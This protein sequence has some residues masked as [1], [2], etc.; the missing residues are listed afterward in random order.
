[1]PEMR[2]S[3]SPSPQPYDGEEGKEEEDGEQA[4]EEEQEADITMVNPENEGATVDDDFDEKQ[5]LK[6][7]PRRRTQTIVDSGDEGT[8]DPFSILKPKQRT[9]GSPQDDNNENAMLPISIPSTNHR[10]SLSSTD[11]RTE[12]EN[13]KENN[14]SLMFDHSENKENKAVVRHGDASGKHPLGART[15]SL[16]GL[17]LGI[18]RRL[19]MS[20]VLHSQGIDA[21]DEDDESEEGRSPLKDLLDDDPFQVTSSKFSTSFAV[22]L[23]Q[24]SPAATLPPDTNLVPFIGKGDS[25]PH[26]PTEPSGI[27]RELLQ[28]GFSDLFESGTE[29][30]KV[31]PF[32]RPAGFGLSESFSDEV[33]TKT[34]HHCETNQRMLTGTSI[35]QT[36]QACSPCA[37]SDAGCRSSACIPNR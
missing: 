36:P 6:V 2:G 16:F 8:E 29:K 34:L 15:S 7:R 12:D 5:I 19:S 11:E 4:V 23:Q 31:N 22:R 28:P 17:E 30:Q 20:P 10:G 3:A 25:Y 14:T 13:D 18:A 37:W 27:G 24:A 33:H 21:D 26:S 35:R 32:K 9:F 1:M